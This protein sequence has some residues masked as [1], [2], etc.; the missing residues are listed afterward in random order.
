VTDPLDLDAIANDGEPYRFKFGGEDYEM[1][2]DIDLTSIAL[3]DSGDPERALERLLGEEQWQRMVESPAAFGIRQLKA[4]L[5]GYSQHLG[6][7]SLGGSLAS[8]GSSHNT[9]IR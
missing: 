4:L 8:P 9:A 5:Q 3:L 7:D 6:M 1:P 2:P